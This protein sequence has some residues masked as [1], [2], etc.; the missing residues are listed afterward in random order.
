MA[1]ESEKMTTTL[2]AESLEW[3]RETYPDAMSDQEAI[4]MAISD[5]RT[6]REWG[7]PDSVSEKTD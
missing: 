3:L 7:K 5:A 2:S 4:R 1:E 6:L